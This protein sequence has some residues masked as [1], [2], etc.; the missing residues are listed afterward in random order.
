VIATETSR[1]LRIDNDGCH[2]GIEGNYDSAEHERQ[3]K[4]E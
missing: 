3:L 4:G 1:L 2:R